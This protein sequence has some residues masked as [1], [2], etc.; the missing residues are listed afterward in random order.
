MRLVSEQETAIRQFVIV[1]I[2]LMSVFK[3]VCAHCYCASLERALFIRH[4][5]PRHVFEA[6]APSRNSTKYRA[7][8]LC[9]NLVAI[10]FIE[11]P[12]TP[13]FFI[14]RSLAFLIL[15]VILRN[16]N[17]LFLG[18]FNYFSYTIPQMASNWDMDTGVRDLKVAGIFLSLILSDLMTYVAKIYQIGLYMLC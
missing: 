12:V 8:D 14:G 5:Q 3:E 17:N 7:D 4:S 11:C 1:T 13:H 10:I 16:K 6:R 9:V 18:S 15:T 2:K